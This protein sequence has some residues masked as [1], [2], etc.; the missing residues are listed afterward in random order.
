MPDAKSVTGTK[1]AIRKRVIRRAKAAPTEPE[2]PEVEEAPVA[3]AP[4]PDPVRE[5]EPEPAPA[6]APVAVQPPVLTPN[7]RVIPMPERPAIMD[8]GPSGGP[9]QFRNGP[10]FDGPQQFRGPGGPRF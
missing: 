8:R 5:A 6:P 9:Q 10:R 4:A 3:E 1:S 7:P 2:T